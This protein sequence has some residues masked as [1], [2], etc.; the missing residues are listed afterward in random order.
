MNQRQ[1][2]NSLHESSANMNTYFNSSPKLERKTSANDAWF[3]DESKPSFN[4]TWQRV[5]P[6]NKPQ[7]I[8]FTIDVSATKKPDV[9]ATTLVRHPTP[10]QALCIGDVFTIK[11]AN[12][13]RY[14]LVSSHYTTPLEVINTNQSEEIESKPK[15]K[16]Q[17]G[18]KKELNSPHFEHNGEWFEVNGSESNAIYPDIL[19]S[20][21]N[22]LD[23]AI[24]KYG[25]VFV[26][27]FDLHQENYTSDNKGVSKFRDRL[28][29]K[30]KRQ[31]KTKDI[32]YTWVREVAT[33]KGQH[34]HWVLFLDGDKIQHSAKLWNIVKALWEK[35][36]LGYGGTVPSINHPFYNID[37]PDIEQVRLDVIYRISYLAKTNT[38]GYRDKSAKDFKSSHL[39][40]KPIN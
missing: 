26:Y 37:I 36:G 24:S 13:V 2:T 8:D 23:A 4:E 18:W 11:S 1:Y 40:P 27:R 30:L 12:T 38:K 21:I 7:I 31:Y 15:R 19:S 5:E 34:Y 10:I 9:S 20:M 14:L 33:G 39:K 29:K 28:I 22:Q 17:D 35:K 6:T 3:F 32:F 25:R 16:I